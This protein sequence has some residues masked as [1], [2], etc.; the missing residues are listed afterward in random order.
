MR[1]EVQNGNIIVKHIAGKL[2]LSDLF[3]KEDKDVQHYVLIVS[4]MMETIS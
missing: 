3:T 1:E 4:Y 2:N